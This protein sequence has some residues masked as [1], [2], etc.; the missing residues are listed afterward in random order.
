MPVVLITGAA[1]FLGSQVASI[2]RQRGYD[3]IAT[4]LTR[5]QRKDLAWDRMDTTSPEQVRTVMTRSHPDAVIHCAALADVKYCEE[6]KER[7]RQVNVVGTRNLASMCRELGSKLIYVSTDQVFRGSITPDRKYSEVDAPDPVNY[8][9]RSKLEGEITIR[10]ELENYVVARTANLYGYGLG[11]SQ[12]TGVALDI[13]TKLKSGNKVEARSDF[14]Q[15]P[16]SAHDY[17]NILIDMSEKPLTGVYHVAGGDLVSRLQYAYKIAEFFR[18]DKN[19]VVT[20]QSETTRNV[21]LDCGKIER[22]LNRKMLS[23]DQGFEILRAVLKED[24]VL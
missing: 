22:A 23:L 11:V 24:G 17:G 13:I 10:E 4:D 19:L 9:G 3:V 7:A 14:Y 18:L 6:N 16:T 8:Y 20:V 15:T 1:G 21:G 12:E 5:S 2:A